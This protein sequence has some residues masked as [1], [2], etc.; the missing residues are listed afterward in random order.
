[1]AAEEKGNKM[2]T[3]NLKVGGVVFLISNLRS[4][5]S[6]KKQLALVILHESE[7]SNMSSKNKELW[8]GGAHVKQPDRNGV[9]GDV[10]EAVVNVIALAVNKADFRRQIKK[11]VEELGLI[12]IRV[13]EAEP[14]KLHLLKYSI[15]EDLSKLAEEVRHTGHLAFDVFCT[16]DHGT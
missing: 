12:L 8:I 6:Q 13:K 14:L 11:E 10:D 2:S 3:S 15:H 16:F 9:L 7:M 1:M 4:C 5:G